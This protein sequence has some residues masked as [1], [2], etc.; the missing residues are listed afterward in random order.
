MDLISKVR[1]AMKQ[2]VLEQPDIEGL[3][4]MGDG[5]WVPMDK[6][7]TAALPK[8]KPY[9]IVEAAFSYQVDRDNG[10]VK[11]LREYHCIW[12]WSTG[13]VSRFIKEK[14]AMDMDTRRTV[15][16]RLINH[17]QRTKGHGADTTIDPEK[18]KGK[19]RKGTEQALP[20][21]EEKVESK[22]LRIRYF[23]H[24]VNPDANINILQNKYGNDGY[25]FWYKL[26]EILSRQKNHHFD[27]NNIYDWG[28]LLKYTGVDDETANNILSILAARRAIDGKLWADK[29]IWCQDL[30]DDVSDAYASKKIEVPT[31]ETQRGEGDMNNVEG[32]LQDA[33]VQILQ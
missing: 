2:N 11:G 22:H 3:S 26:L 5:N 15:E 25:A 31:K 10:T 18:I 14:R 28:Y 13:R 6:G 9:T 8:K 23:P 27:C 33:E 16:F 7:L 17:L 21:S 12:G 29:I 4:S 32:G 1:T 30:V 24:Y 20:P 19:E